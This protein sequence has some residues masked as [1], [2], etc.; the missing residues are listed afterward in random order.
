[1]LLFW[2][3]CWPSAGL[4]LATSYQVY[5]SYWLCLPASGCIFITNQRGSCSWNVMLS[6]HL[7]KS[8][9][10][11]T[12]IREEELPLACN[13]EHFWGEF[14]RCPAVFCPFPL[15][16]RLTGFDGLVW[17][18]FTYRWLQIQ[19]TSGSRVSFLTLLCLGE[20]FPGWFSDSLL[21]SPVAGLSLGPHSLLRRWPK[22]F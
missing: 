9:R 5:I 3:Y 6:S 11:S 17:L 7:W 10:K 1:M 13:A 16:C 4:C 21:G 15:P 22:D 20:P 18:G 2:P 8:P 12:G 14:Q 19:V